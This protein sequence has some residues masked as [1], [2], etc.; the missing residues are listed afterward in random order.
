MRV[1]RR[2][3][4]SARGSSR[5]YEGDLYGALPGSLR[6]RVSVLVA[7][8]PYVPSAEVQLMPREAR[9][10]EPLGTLDGG[11]DGL[12]LQRRVVAGAASW[13]RPGGS[14]L[15]ETSEEQADATAALFERAGLPPE[16]VHDDDLSATVVI[17]GS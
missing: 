1:A 4:P 2:N 7:N 10:H 13:L 3:L 9:D 12:D 15:V 17:G 11:A 5:V 14:L 16:V 6:G 8:A